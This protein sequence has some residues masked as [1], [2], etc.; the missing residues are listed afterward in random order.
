MIVN[1]ITF[2]NRI[3]R[4]YEDEKDAREYIKKESNNTGF[5]ECTFRIIKEYVE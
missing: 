3:L 2:G 4:V 1:I 5:S